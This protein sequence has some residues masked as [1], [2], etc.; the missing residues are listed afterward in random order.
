MIVSFMNN[1]FFFS[2]PYANV[3]AVVSRFISSVYREKFGWSCL[4]RAQST[5]PAHCRSHGDGHFFY[6]LVLLPKTKY[7]WTSTNCFFSAMATSLYN[8]QPS[9]FRPHLYNSHLSMMVTTL[10]W[11]SL[12]NGLL[13]TNNHLSSTRTTP[14]QW[15]HLYNSHLSTTVTF[16]Q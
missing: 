11:P 8:S 16:L 12:F 1:N 4:G 10:Q 3:G 6:W 13:S 9:T 2:I 14:L 7:S 5:W 15:H